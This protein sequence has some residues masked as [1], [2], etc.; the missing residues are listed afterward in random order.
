MFIKC[1]PLVPARFR[2]WQCGLMLVWLG[3]VATVVPALATPAT[4]R[5]LA[6]PGY[7]QPE[8]VQ[9]FERASGAQ[10]VLTVIDS[11]AALWQ[12]INQ[13]GQ[14]FDVWAINT[15]ELQ[16]CIAAGLVAPIDLA[17]IPNT[18]QQLT[19]FRNLAGIAGLVHQQQVFGI[20]YTY[21]EM[22]LIYD[23]Q[24]VKTPPQSVAAL[25]DPRWAGKVLLYNGASHNFSLAAQSLGLASPFAIGKADWPAAVGKLIAL[26][27]NALGFYT[28]P[29]ESAEWFKR[30]NAALMFANY[31]SQ[32]FQMLKAAGLDVGYAVP[33]EGALAW[34]DVWAVAR[35]SPN[36]ALAHQWINHLLSP[37]AAQV[38]LSSEGLS[39]TLTEAPDIHGRD[40]LI[41]LEP[42]EDTAHR[43]TLW[44]RIYSGD[45]A[46]RTLAP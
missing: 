26:R 40:R 30:R 25:W 24:Q 33:K 34:L 21:S 35:N 46:A 10:V 38:L 4:L 7:A 15:A 6:W 12:K 20:P 27:R 1:L 23:R 8:V 43:E 2:S 11:D 3:W 42:V 45:S 5:V 22:G 13:P 41:W 14:T 36:R 9:A 28:Q 37:A 17:Q 18:A 19:R 29:E 39:N 32:Q 16:R 44:R 31:G